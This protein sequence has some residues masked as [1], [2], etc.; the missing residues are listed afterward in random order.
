[1]IIPF[2]GGGVISIIT[3]IYV[4]VATRLLNESL[5]HNLRISIIAINAIWIFLII[6]NY[7]DLKDYAIVKVIFI[8]VFFIT[9]AICMCHIFWADYYTIFPI[10]AI[11]QETNGFRGTDL[12][13]FCTLS[14]SFKNY[15]YASILV[16]SSAFH[17]YHFIGM[18]ILGLVAKITGLPAIFVYSYLYP[19][20]F[21][22][23]LVFLLLYVP[24][25]YRS[26]IGTTYKNIGFSDVVVVG[27]FLSYLFINRRMADMVTDWKND[28]LVSASFI[29]SAIVLCSFFCLLPVLSRK[30]RKKYNII[31]YYFI[32]PIYIVILSLTKISVG[33]LFALAISYYLVRISKKNIKLA[34]YY[35]VIM[36]AAYKI[37]AFIYSPITSLVASETKYSFLDYYNNYIDKELL[38]LHILFAFFFSIVFIIWS[39]R[40]EGTLKDVWTSVLSKKLLTS[41][42]LLFICIVGVLPGNIIHIGS[43]QWYFEVVQQIVAVELLIAY[44]VPQ[45]IIQ[46]IKGSHFIS[47]KLGT[48]ILCLCMTYSYIYNIWGQIKSFSLIYDGA[49]EEFASSQLENSYYSEIKNIN[50]ITK[51]KKKDYYIYIDD[52]AG[53]WWRFDNPRRTALYFY[54]AMTGLVCVGELYNDDDGNLYLNDGTNEIVDYVYKSKQKEP[55]MTWHDAVEKAEKDGKKGIFRIKMGHIVYLKKLK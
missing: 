9:L 28:W 5:V 35:M 12:L 13:Y 34:I 10:Q 27:A 8:V 37:P 50:E 2:L 25:L 41:E 14:E 11:N 17:F 44:A 42:V 36:G 38:G 24:A 21:F 19:I 32:T 46:K 31:F 18:A 4:L 49:K 33:V 45:N 7:K 40:K 23:I 1:M 3:S 47:V 16:N 54:P 26:I 15:G 51:G 55:R 6:K 29:S 30:E 52:T 48:I 43:S 22:S 53:I 39:I 20:I